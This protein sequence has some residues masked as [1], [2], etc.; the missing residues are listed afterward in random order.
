LDEA[1]AQ[2][3]QEIRHYCSME[4]FRPFTL[5][6]EEY[7]RAKEENIT[8][9]A[10]RRHSNASLPFTNGSR[11]Q[12]TDISGMSRQFSATEENLLNVLSAYGIRL[13]SSKDLVR[14]YVDEYQAEL[15]VIAHVVAYFDISSKRLID[16]IPKIFEE[17]FAHG[18]AIKLAKSF[19]TKLN[20][21]G[22]RGL[23]NCA[24]YVRDEPDIQEKRRE[25]SR[26][27]R[28]L[29]RALKTVEDFHK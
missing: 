7:I 6:K 22:E 1:A 26:K 18:F 5:A 21:T 24:R 12:L 10:L 20:L 29:M 23:D 11:F 8:A 28:I 2:A 25:L 9:F 27:Q 19:T 3:R 4:N 16:D 13:S 14:I 17:R 15:D